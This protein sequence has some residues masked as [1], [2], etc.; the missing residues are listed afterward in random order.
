MTDMQKALMISGIGIVLVFAGILILWG[1][2]ELLVR[3]TTKK[4]TPTENKSKESQPTKQTLPIKQAAA[5]AAVAA[6][7]C[8]QNTTIVSAP[9]SQH[10]ALSPWQSLHRGRSYQQQTKQVK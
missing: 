1:I 5:A 7:I 6:A 8:M 2:M 9:R 10:E 4:E 3:V